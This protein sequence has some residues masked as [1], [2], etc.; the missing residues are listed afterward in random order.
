VIAPVSAPVPVV[1]G[2]VAV[3]GPVPVA[4]TL[5]G[6]VGVSPLLPVVTPPLSVGPPVIV[7]VAV[8]VAVAE[9][10]SLSARPASPQ[11]VTQRP[12]THPSPTP[13]TTPIPP[14]Y[15]SPASAQAGRLLPGEA[16]TV[17]RVHALQGLE[18]RALARLF[19]ELSPAEARR[20]LSGVIRRGPALLTAPIAQVR[21]EGL[22]ALRARA[23]VPTLELRSE[24]ASQVDA[25]VKYLFV[26]PDAALLESVRI[27]L[28]QPDRFTVCVSSQVG[29]ALACAFCATGRLGLTRN[30]EAW[31]IV[32]QV[33]LVRA[34]L[35]AGARVRGVVFQGMGE[36]LANLDR[37]LAAIAVLSDPSA[38][39]IDAR[40]ITVCTAG[41]PAGIR[42]LAREAPQVRLG[43]SLA[44]AR[45]EL[46]RRLMPIDGAQPLHEALAAAR[47]HA[48]LTGLAPMFAVTLLHGHND[49]EAD[50]AALA[51]LVR[52]FHARTGLRPRLS[53][54]PYNPIGQGDPFTRS[55]DAVE[56]AFRDNLAARGVFTHKRYSGGGDVDAAC[57]QLAAR[58]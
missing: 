17:R 12:S 2:S 38:L 53:L 13:R 42:R 56:S 9:F 58:A 14:P 49:G 44:S 30:L 50:A 7:T 3:P 46:R 32:E 55:P 35:P 51:D 43:L 26:A 18:P 31:E 57:G 19:P 37:V 40:A 24:R 25:F 41:L 10:E 28:A 27:P 15:R 33:R 1:P 16:V 52:D 4:L 48:A 8:T 5:P 29:C 20:V 36:P 11:P 54:I 6:P 21:R 22:A 23:H 39:A 45:P 47:E 34:R